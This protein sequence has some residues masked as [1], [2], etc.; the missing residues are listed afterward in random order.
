MSAT[1]VQQVQVWRIPCSGP[2][3]LSGVKALIDAGEIIAAD[4]VAVMGKTEGNGCVNDFTREYASTALAATCWAPHVRLSRRRGRCTG[5]WRL[6]MSGG[7]EGVLSPHFTVFSAALACPMHPRRL[8]QKRLTIGIALHARLP[9]RKNW[10]GI[11]QV[12]ATAHRGAPT[13]C[14]DAGIESCGRRALRAGQV[15][16]CCR[17][18]PQVSATRCARG[19]CAGH[20]RQL[21]VDG[22]FARRL[23]A[24][25]GRSRWAKIQHVEE[26]RR[27][28]A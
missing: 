14:D 28:R 26:I 6:V 25:R 12:D 27:R 8:G 3:D 10:A 22:L 15:P 7:T 2:G 19:V 5:A 20:P 24:R 1:R 23:G 13:P 18:R 4:I 21:R 16:A 17:P 9:A 11:A